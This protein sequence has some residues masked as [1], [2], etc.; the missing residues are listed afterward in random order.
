MNNVDI[1]KT[2]THLSL[3]SGYDGI[4]M[5]LRGI[6]PALREVA[7][8]EIEAY[9]IANLVAKM[10]ESILPPAPVYTDIK[11]FPFARFRGCVDI[12]SG[13]FPCQP[14][15]AAG[16]RRASE[17]PRHLWPYIKDGIGLCRPRMVLLENVEGIISAKMPDGQSVLHHVLS[18]LEGLGYR[19]TAGVFSAAEVGASHQRKRVFILGV[20][21]ARSEELDRVQQ[22]ER[23]IEDLQVREPSAAMAN[24]KRE[25]SQRN[26]EAGGAGDGFGGGEE[27]R[28]ATTGHCNET[29]ADTDSTRPQGDECTGGTN[30]KGWQE[31]TGH[32]AECRTIPIARPGEQQFAHEEPRTVFNGKTRVLNH[33]WVCQLMGVPFGWCSLTKTEVD[34]LADVGTIM[35]H[36]R[37]SQILFTMLHS[38]DSQT[39]QREARMPFDFLKKEILQPSMSCG[40]KDTRKPIKKHKSKEVIESEGEMLRGLQNNGKAARPPHKR[41]LERQQDGESENSLCIMSRKNTLEDWKEIREKITSGMQG[42]WENVPDSCGDVCDSLPEIQEVWESLSD[43]EA[44]QRLMG[45]CRRQVYFEKAQS[46]NRIDALRACGNGVVPATAERAF[47]ILINRIN[48]Q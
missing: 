44:Y 2:I 39:L 27:I 34:T 20:A 4:G 12:L 19:A 17:D 22:P 11:T 43:E 37:Q 6:F 15:S 1:T 26:D 45:A 32:A 14:F 33:E 41:K 13:G 31:P 25:G 10:E 16:K 47:R 8:V 30:S 29:M 9:A 48:N 46:V 3:C 42:L 35:N 21:N 28:R 40:I 36:E 18:E 23:W 38:T 24:T 5:G 7:H